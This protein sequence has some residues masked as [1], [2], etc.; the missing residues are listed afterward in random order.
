M[1]RIYTIG[2][3]VVACHFRSPEPSGR[4]VVNGIPSTELHMHRILIIAALVA[5]SSLASA[6]AVNVTLSE[7]KVGLDRDTVRAGPVTFKVKNAGT[8]TH[9][10]FVRGEGVAKGSHEIPAGENA[11]LT[12]TLKPGT[13]ELYCPMSDLTHKMAG[14]SRTLVV[15]AADKPTVTKKPGS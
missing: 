6:Q 3:Y 8:V 13:Y 9:G 10:F 5:S 7:W 1:A 12:V 15:I 14:M 2:Y 11:P 4:P